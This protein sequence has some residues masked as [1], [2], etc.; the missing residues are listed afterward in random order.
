MRKRAS[1]FAGVVAIT[2]LPQ[3]D[4]LVPAIITDPF[5]YAVAIPAVIFLGLSKGGFSGVGIAATPLLALYLPP[6]EAAALLLPVLITQDLISIYVYRREWDA[7]NL[8]I[9]LPGAVAGMTLAWL[10]ASYIS[11]NAVRITVGL[12]GLIFVIDVWRKRARIEPTRMGPAGG[13]F[14]GAV[15]GF[16]SFMTQAGGP[17][18]QVYVLPQ[19]LP[20]LVLVGTTTIFF[21][22]VNALKIVPYF[23]LGQFHA[24]NF[25]TSLALLPMAIIANFM[26]IWLVKHTPTNLFYNIAYALLLV[27]SLVLLWQGCSML[28]R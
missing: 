12:I 10:L 7:S 8:K 28:W 1:P 14:W 16:T 27:I 15:S 25:A 22:V 23:A 24:G 9:M 26:G 11:D 3:P 21:A 17:P 13:V 18:F 5:F 19:R 20:K 4:L 6:L 2:A